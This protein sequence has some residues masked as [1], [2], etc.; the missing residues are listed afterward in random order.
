MSKVE[1]DKYPPEYLFW[2]KRIEGQVKHTMYEHPEFFTQ[3]AYEKNLVGRMAKRIIG[4]IV[5]GMASGNS[6]EGGASARASFV[7]E[8]EVQLASA[9]SGIAGGTPTAS[10]QNKDGV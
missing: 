8:D 3:I 2:K 1:K 4:E 7:S 5:A 9:S 6:S 10:Y